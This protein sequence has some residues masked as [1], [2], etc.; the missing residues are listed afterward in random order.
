[1]KIHCISTEQIKQQNKH[2]TIAR[3][4]MFWHIR[5]IEPYGKPAYF[6]TINGGNK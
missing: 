1:M 4:I 3:L 5:E 6:E 2:N